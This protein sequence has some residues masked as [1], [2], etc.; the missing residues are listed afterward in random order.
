MTPSVIAG[1]QLLQ[2][3]AGTDGESSEEQGCPRYLPEHVLQ[4]LGCYQLQG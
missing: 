2:Q 4:L 1:T 3:P